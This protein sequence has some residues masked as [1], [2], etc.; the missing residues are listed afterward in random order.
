MV[1]PP[2]CDAPSPE[3][4]GFAPPRQPPFVW[5]MPVSDTTL[6]GHVFGKVPHAGCTDV[7]DVSERACEKF[8]HWGVNA[9]Q[10]KLFRVPGGRDKA[11]AIEADPSLAAGVLIAANKLAADEAVEPGSWLLARVPPPPAKAP[12]ASRRRAGGPRAH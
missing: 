9:G 3:H 7:A 2:D 10:V 6:A 11:L 1:F 12:G 4:N 5:V 8:P